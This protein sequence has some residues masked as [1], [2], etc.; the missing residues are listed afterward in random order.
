MKD[1]GYPKAGQFTERR[2]VEPEHKIKVYKKDKKDKSGKK[3]KSVLDDI[4]DDADILSQVSDAP[5]PETNRSQA[6]NAILQ[7]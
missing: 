7:K 2:H 3:T 6:L 4:G 5:K 1:N